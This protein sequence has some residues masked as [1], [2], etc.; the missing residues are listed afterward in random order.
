MAGVGVF[1]IRDIPEDTNIFYGQPD[2]KW[3]TFKMSQ[4]KN[5]DKQVLKMIDDFF[6]IEKDQTVQIPEGAFADMNI[7]YYPNNSETPNAKTTDG[8]YTFVSLRDIK[9]GEEITVAYSTYDE[10][11]KVDSVILT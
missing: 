1:A 8:G 7:S 2:P 11:Y 10:K 6:V 9:K 5:L 4:L 3:H